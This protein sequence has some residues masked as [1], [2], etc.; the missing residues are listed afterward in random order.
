MKKI[1][2][3]LSSNIYSGAENVVCTIINNLNT[4]E[5]DCAYCSPYG[6]IEE[7]VKNKK[8]KFFGLNR[9]NKNNLKKIIEEYKPEI[10]HANDY[11]ASV[12][13][14]LTGFNG[15]IISHLHNNCPFAKTWNLKTILY[16]YTLKKYSKI[17]GVSDKV[18]KEAV[19]KNKIE[20]KYVTI[21]N[22]IDKENIINK[23]TMAS[24]YNKEYDLFF[25][26]RLTDQKNPQAFI[27]IVRKIKEMDA[28]ISSV[29]TCFGTNSS[30]LSF[31]NFNSFL[32]SFA[33]SDSNIFFNTA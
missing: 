24:I 31:I 20:N 33:S 12:I 18:I 9:M 27:E 14:A 29:V 7:V 17:I 4:A 1:L 3:V 5:Y 21:Y 13:V 2:Y 16:S 22:Y 32:S 11:K 8:I 26:G 23:S 6:P 25:L 30:F 19:F 10:I 15:K 28:N